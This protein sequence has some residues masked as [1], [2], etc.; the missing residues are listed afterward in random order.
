KV[1]DYFKREINISRYKTVNNEIKLEKGME[2]IRG[3]YKASYQELIIKDAIE[4]H[5][6][7]EQKNFLRGNNRDFNNPRI[8]TLSL[9]FIH[10]INS[11][12][13]DDG[14]LKLTFERLL[15]KKLSQLIQEY[16]LK[17]QTREVEYLDFLRAT[18]ARLDLHSKEQ[19]V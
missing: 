4:R 9:F 17:R 6:E 18:Q 8:K 19:N 3:I 16:E 14:W 7:I 2:L 13:D 5:F 11:Y 1:V 15:R 10:S 12:R